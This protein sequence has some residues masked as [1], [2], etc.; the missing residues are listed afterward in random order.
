MRSHCSTAF[1]RK[2]RFNYT[3]TQAA[4]ACANPPACDPAYHSKP[5]GNAIRLRLTTADCHPSAPSKFHPC[6]E[7]SLRRLVGRSAFSSL[8]VSPKSFTEDVFFIRVHWPCPQCFA[9]RCRRGVYSWLE[10]FT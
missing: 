6:H 3:T 9:Q 7:A 2:R 8:A 1:C 10:P 5:D 4:R